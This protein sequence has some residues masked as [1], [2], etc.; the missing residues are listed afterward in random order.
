MNPGETRRP[1][2]RRARRSKRNPS[3][4]NLLEMVER[5]RKRKQQIPRDSEADVELIL[6]KEERK[7]NKF[8]IS[9]N[10]L[11]LEKKKMKRIPKRMRSRRII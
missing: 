2:E 11:D 7:D 1:L 4:V 6:K 3:S 9:V 8:W 5:G 10:V